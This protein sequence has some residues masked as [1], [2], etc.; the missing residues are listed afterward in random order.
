R[1]HREAGVR[2]RAQAEQGVATTEPMRLEGVE[3]RRDLASAVRRVEP[4]NVRVHRLVAIGIADALDIDAHGAD[5]SCRP[6]T[7]ALD[8]HPVRPGSAHGAGVQEYGA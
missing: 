6:T 7:R 4:P 2:T 3:D 5:A 1:G 8:P